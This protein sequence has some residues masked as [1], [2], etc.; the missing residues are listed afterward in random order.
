MTGDGDQP[1]VDPQTLEDRDMLVY[2]TVATLE[3]LGRT[4]TRSQIGAAAGVDDGELDELLRSL[5]ERH[6]LV[7]SD[8]AG[9][10]AFQPA[11]RDFSAV[12]GDPEGPQRLP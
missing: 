1:Y 7:R 5:I 12:P 3:F 9:E 10:P 11:R 4:P 6:L 8:A 2:E